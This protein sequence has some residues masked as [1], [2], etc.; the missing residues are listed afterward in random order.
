MSFTVFCHSDI[1]GFLLFYNLPFIIQKHAYLEKL[2]G[3]YKSNYLKR[4]Q[5]K[6]DIYLIY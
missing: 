1:S 2:N 4:N 5:G 6:K 3:L